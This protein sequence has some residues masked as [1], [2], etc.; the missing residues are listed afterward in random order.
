MPAPTLLIWTQKYSEVFGWDPPARS[1]N[2]ST[3]SLLKQQNVTKTCRKYEDSTML[4]HWF[5]AQSVYVLYLS[6]THWRHNV[7]RIL[8]LEG[9]P[10]AMKY[11]NKFWCHPPFGI[12]IVWAYSPKTHICEIFQNWRIRAPYFVFAVDALSKVYLRRENYYKWSH[13]FCTLNWGLDLHW[14]SGLDLHGDF[15]ADEVVSIVILQ[16]YPGQ[17]I[18]S[19]GT[20]RLSFGV[21]F[22]NV[23]EF[24][25]IW[26]LCL[27]IRKGVKNYP[28]DLVRKETK[29]AK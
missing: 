12:V 4:T 1:S 26:Y 22:Q 23:S 19:K 24:H 11:Y 16:L 21:G 15:K 14:D 18:T 10:I 9:P 5:M 28:A 7:I 17:D 6:I 20:F 29:S 3:Q 25:H 2:D 13:M 8:S 27:I